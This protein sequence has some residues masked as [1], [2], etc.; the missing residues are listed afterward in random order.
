M[1]EYDGLAAELYDEFWNQE[2]LDDIPFFL[3]L[4]QTVEGPLL[5]A[6]CGS[7]RV[8]VPLAQA[9]LEVTGIDSSP[10]MVERCRANLEAAATQ[11][12]PGR[13]S[14]RE[15][16]ASCRTPRSRCRE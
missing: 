1:T 10:A 2:D 9:G 13:R 16:P 6:G 3:H 7:G 8:L 14:P 15:M 11:R 4:A 12:G 5:D